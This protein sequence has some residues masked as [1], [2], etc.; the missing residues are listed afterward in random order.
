[1]VKG[2]SPVTAV[3]TKKKKLPKRFITY[4]ASGRSPVVENLPYNHMVKGSSTGSAIA[5]REKKPKLFKSKT[6]PVPIAQW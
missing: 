6:L 3:C 5:M 4:F 2:L 1:M